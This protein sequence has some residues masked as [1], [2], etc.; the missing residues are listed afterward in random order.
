MNA[1]FPTRRLP[2][3]D[4]AFPA[5]GFGAAAIGTLHGWVEE[6]DAV[7]T[8]RAAWDGGIRYFDV[9]PLYGAGLGEQRVGAFLRTRPRGDYLL[10]SK[11]GWLA[12]DGAVRI[13]YSEAGTITIVEASLA[14]LGV[15]RLDA[16]FI[17]DLD[18]WNHGDAYPQRF[19]EAMQGAY[20]ALA[21]LRAEGRVGAIGIGVNDPAVCLQALDHGDF[22][23][24]LMAGR[25]TLLDQAAGEALLPA[26]ERRGV[27]VIAGAP[28]NTGLLA[29]GP[30]PGARFF[31]KAAD[32][33]RMDQAKAI[34]TIAER[35]GVTLGAAALQFPLGHPAVVSVLAGPRLASQ[36]AQCAAWAREPI[37]AAFW[38]EL[39][40]SGL[41]HADTPTP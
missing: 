29:T 4:I 31:H 36:A 18:S 25:Y 41:L 6:A 15:D 19:A 35:H 21:R 38:D 40:Q 11:C 33:A 30:Q 14:R 3:A 22:D 32:G 37:P 12:E 9:A 28:F 34:A 39:K 23:L 10:S 27:R 1:G 24:F 5:L 8:L 17:H 26:C 2:R 13:D 20:P 16:V 7:A